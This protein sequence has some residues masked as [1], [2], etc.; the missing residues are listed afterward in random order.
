MTHFWNN[1]DL[2]TKRKK[3]RKTNNLNNLGAGIPKG[4]NRVANIGY[5]NLLL[6][7]EILSFNNN[8]IN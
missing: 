2:G 3:I 1:I 7:E 4:L 8:Y 6:M 5:G